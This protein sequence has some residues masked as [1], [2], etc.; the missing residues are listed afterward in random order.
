MKKKILTI[1][2]I[3]GRIIER[4]LSLEHISKQFGAPANDIAYAAMCQAICMHGYT[5]PEKADDKR[6]T[7]IAPS[8]IET[9]TFTINEMTDETTAD[10]GPEVEKG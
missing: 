10:S 7:H 8:Q 2:L 5:D 1:K 3:S 6:Y 4:D 9:V